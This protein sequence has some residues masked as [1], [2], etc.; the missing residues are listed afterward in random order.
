MEYNSFYFFLKTNLMNNFS[1]SK[2]KTP[3]S[4]LS[5]LK[6]NERLDVLIFIQVYYVI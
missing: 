6:T 4:C 5:D 3:N 2:T 1:K